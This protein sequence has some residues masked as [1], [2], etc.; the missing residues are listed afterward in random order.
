[1]YPDKSKIYL[2]K[3]NHKSQTYGEIEGNRKFE[4]GGDCYD[5]NDGCCDWNGFIC[6]CFYISW[7]FGVEKGINHFAS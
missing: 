2:Y 5:G 6:T 7:L 1:L 4:F 3:G